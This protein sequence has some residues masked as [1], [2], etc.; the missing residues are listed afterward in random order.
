M[1]RSESSPCSAF[2]STGTPS[3]GR[4]VFD[5][6]MPGRCAAPPA[7]AMITCRP[8][9]SAASAYAKSLS[10]VRCADT[11]SFSYRTPS[12][13]SVSAACR[14]VSQSEREPMMIPTTG[15]S[16]TNRSLLRP[17]LLHEQRRDRAR[18]LAQLR[19]LFVRVRDAVEELD[20]V[21]LRRPVSQT[22]DRE[23]PHRDVRIPRGE[24][25]EQRT[26]GV[27]VSGMGARQALER[28]ERR[29]SCRRAVVLESSPQELELLP[30]PELCDRAIRL[31][32]NPVV[33][34]AG[35]RLDL[36]VPLR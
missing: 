7:P 34:V 33:G 19:V 27:H 29:P 16:L 10:G 2:D 17:R 20:R 12:S 28:D 15:G 4:R 23:A 36:L 25:V 26:E 11:T 35:A 24:V 3:T 1:E 22:H 6:V 14:I 5:E 8:R 9:A 13:S 31:G 32:T 21:A 30:K 18:R